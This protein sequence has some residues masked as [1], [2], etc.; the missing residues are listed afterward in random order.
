MQGLD[1]AGAEII[2]DLAAVRRNYT[3]LKERLGRD[4]ELAAVLKANAYGLGVRNVARTLFQAGC[5]T[6]FVATLDEG[7]VLRAVIKEARI[8]VLNGI[9]ANEL[10]DFFIHRLNPVLNS[11]SQVERWQSKMQATDGARLAAALHV[12][13]GMNRLG[14]SPQDVGILAEAPFKKFF[15]SLLMSH[16]AC[17]EIPLH[18]L[19][20]V[21]LGRFS[22]VLGILKF[23][24][25]KGMTLSLANSSGI[26]LGSD[27]HFD[28]VRSGAALFG[29]NPTP[30]QPNPMSEVINFKAKIVQVRRVD[31]P[32]TVGYGAA[33]RVKESARI[34]TVPVG[35][36]DGFIRSLGG[37]ASAYVGN[38][39]VPV[40][41]RVSMDAITLDVSTVPED[42][43]QPG[44]IVDLIGGRRAL[45]DVASEAGTIGYEMLTRISGRI[46]RT[47]LDRAK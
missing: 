23:H 9:V 12:D 44:A 31:S 20:G 35:Y 25:E 4:T 32:M 38:F 8:Y 26:F 6:Y 17:A 46:P 18:P 40:I 22:E 11:K 21:Q 41:G 28:L 27:F 39:C 16:L 45:D 37:C 1:R 42:L 3:Y 33:H 47:Y 29:I 30:L 5:R 13:T 24:C 7:I 43:A 15:L 10:D 14:L 36:A 19:N 34:A 2:I